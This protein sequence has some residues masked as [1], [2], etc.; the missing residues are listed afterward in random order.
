MDRESPEQNARE[1][2][3]TQSSNSGELSSTNKM[4]LIIMKTMKMELIIQ[5][6]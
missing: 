1:G 4:T 3:L 6:L 5:I 2:N